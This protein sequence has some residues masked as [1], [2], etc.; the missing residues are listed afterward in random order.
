MSINSVILAKRALA[1]ALVKD[2]GFLVIIEKKWSD[3]KAS[4]TFDSWKTIVNRTIVYSSMWQLFKES[5]TL[6]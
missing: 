6:P 2:K 5:W 1:L 3:I 4:K